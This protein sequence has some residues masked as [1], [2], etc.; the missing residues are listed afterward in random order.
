MLERDSHMDPR[1]IYDTLAIEDVRTAAGFLR[2][3]YQESS[4]A[5]GFV[6]LEPPP[7]LTRD[8]TGTVS[9]ARRLWHA[10]NVPNLM[11]KVVAG[12]EGIPAIEQLIGEG[13][14]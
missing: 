6:S 10:V 11:I 3:A 14:T 12:R 4:G 1:A 7:Q 2:S 13:S 8:T 5:D 9:E